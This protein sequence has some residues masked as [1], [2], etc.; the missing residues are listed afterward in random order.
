M[1]KNTLS[2]EE[3]IAKLI[4]LSK[5]EITEIVFNNALC[6]S[7]V[8]SLPKKFKYKSYDN[9]TLSNDEINSRHN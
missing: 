5:I 1:A 4:A 2:E 6:Y 9:E 3:L 7:P 8:P